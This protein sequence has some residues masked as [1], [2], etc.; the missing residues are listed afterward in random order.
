[1][2]GRWVLLTDISTIVLMSDFY[3]MRRTLK[4]HD[5]QSNCHNRHHND[6]N[7]L[8]TFSMFMALK[9]CRYRIV[10]DIIVFKMLMIIMMMMT[11]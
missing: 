1:M 3:S 10:N 5:H 8:L 11:I 4:F 9:V 6:H 7:Q 2:E